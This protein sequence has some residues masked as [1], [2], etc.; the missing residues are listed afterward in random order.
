MATHSFCHSISDFPKLPDTPSNISNLRTQNLDTIE[1]FEPL[2]E[3]LGKLNILNIFV[4]NNPENI[5]NNLVFLIWIYLRSPDI[6]PENLRV[7]LADKLYSYATEQEYINPD[8]E[9][10]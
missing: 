8:L 5:I 10:Q 3:E 6:F 7:R 4:Q 1:H 2:P 9:K